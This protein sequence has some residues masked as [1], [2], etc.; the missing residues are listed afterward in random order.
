MPSYNKDMYKQIILEHYDYPHNK[1]NVLENKEDYQN[2]HNK[3]ESCI[4]DFELFIK[5]E[6][7]LIIDIKFMGVGCAISTASTDILC[8][9][10]LNKS[11][12]E[13]QDI[14]DEYKKM[15]DNVEFDKDIIDEAIAF[16]NINQQAN[17]VKCALICYNSINSLIEKIKK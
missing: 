16:E 6:N 2:F 13:A 12:S 15:I 17:R 3:S 9:I 14:I 10:I 1:V 7:D 11:L 5:L 8:N 4:D